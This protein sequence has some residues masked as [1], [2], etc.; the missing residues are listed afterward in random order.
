MDEDVIQARIRF[1]AAGR[2][3]L[4]DP[5]EHS[6]RDLLSSYA[7]LH[8][9]LHGNEAGL[10]EQLGLIEINARNILNGLP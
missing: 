5:S 6:I 9:A 3:F 7:I 10:D 1:R 2:R 4:A 8:V